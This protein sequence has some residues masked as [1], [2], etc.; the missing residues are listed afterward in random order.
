MGN[1]EFDQGYDDL[2]NRVMAPYDADDQPVRRRRVAVHRRER[3]HET[4]T[5]R[6]AAGPDA[7]P[8]TSV[9]V[10]G[11]LRRC[12][13]RAPSGA[14][15]PGWDR[16]TSTSPTSSTE[17]NEAAEDLKADG[18]DVIVLLVHEGAPSTNCATMDDDPTS[19]FGQIVDGVND[20]IDA[21]VSGHTHLAYNCSFP[22][23]GWAGSCRDRASGGLGRPVR[24]GPDQ[25]VFTVDHGDR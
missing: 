16:R 6:H 8:R 21:I 9:G 25:L 11:R 20:D 17:V 5:T 12:G 7:G 13:H 2:V 1:H 3:P 19:D 14:G 4:P 24:R 22:V 15:Q 10:E 18:A 23:P